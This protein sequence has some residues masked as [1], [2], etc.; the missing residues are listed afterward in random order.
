MPDDPASPPVVPPGSSPTCLVV[1]FDLAGLM[2]RLG[3]DCGTADDQEA[4][5][6]AEQ[7]ALAASPEPPVEVPGRVAALLPT[8]AGLAAWLASTGIG[9]CSDDELPDVA[10]GYRRLAA[11]AQAQ[12]LSTVAEIASRT[13]IRR[14]RADDAGRP[15]QVLPEAGAEVALALTMSQPTAMDWTALAT[16]LR[17]Q[18]PVTAAALTD[19]QIDL[20]GARIIAEATAPLPDETARAVEERV[21]A[22]AHRQTTAQLR[23]A[24][25]RAVIAAD[26]DG[27]DNRRQH[28]ERH[29]K[30]VLYPDA[31]GTAMLAGSALPAVTAAAAMARI[32]AIA[33]AMKTAGSSGGLD[34]LRAYVMLGLLLGT[35]PSTSP[36][37]DGPRP[38][39]P[40]GD[41]RPGNPP[42]RGDRLP[43]AEPRP[44]APPADP[45]PDEPRPDAPPADPPPDE[46]LDLDAP[47][48][49]PPLPAGLPGS[50]AL[51]TSA[52]G[53]PTRRATGRPTPGLLDVLLPWSALTAR[54]Y[55]EPT[56]LG[57]VG[58]V[59]PAQTG[60]LLDLAIRHPATEWRIILTDEDGHAQAV[61]RLRRN[62]CSPPGRARAGPTTTAPVVGRVTVT[63]PHSTLSDPARPDSGRLAEALLR[64]ANR[65][66]VRERAGVRV[67]PGVRGQAGGTADGECGHHYATPAYRPTPRLREFV[68]ARDASCTFPPCGQPAWRADL[69][70]TIPWQQGG[71]TCACNLSARCRTH[72]KIK[73]LPGWQL[74]QPQPGTL[75]WTTP[76]GR[77]YTVQ[78]NRYPI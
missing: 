66:A 9:D 54:P 76:V 61:E 12:E 46:P 58:P 71:P 1:D 70:H 72:H 47:V 69:D 52:D 25:R 24:V 23:A 22:G 29:A 74:N 64:A 2:T 19:G 41:P 51:P 75:R 15:R 67:R 26:P 6:A 28:A 77:S 45:S 11:W 35:L 5:F 18:L 65:A 36:P 10:L 32:T 56:L 30:V 73:Q 55:G 7:E 78:P 53:A 37:T 27:A 14:E 21:L 8:G 57:R 49:W 44:A 62:T 31:D 42:D 17:W 63:I 48:S 59:T 50:A 20:A 60:Q 68:I 38:D 43:P 33:R 39:D 13:A 16:R 34:Y 4:V 40:T 3:I